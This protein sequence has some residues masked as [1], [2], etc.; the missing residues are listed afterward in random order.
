MLIIY[1]ELIFITVS[2]KEAI[3]QFG[4]VYLMIPL[5]VF[6]QFIFLFSEQI[7]FTDQF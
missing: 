1:S 4:M 5:D 7:V 3:K 6:F 2:H